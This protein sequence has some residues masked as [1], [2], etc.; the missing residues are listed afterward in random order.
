MVIRSSP[1]RRSDVFAV[2]VENVLREAALQHCSERVW[3]YVLVVLARLQASA[4][5]C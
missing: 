1:C 4:V 2:N 5:G 3:G